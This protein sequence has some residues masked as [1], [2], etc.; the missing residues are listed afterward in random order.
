MKKAKHKDKIKNKFKICILLTLGSLLLNA[1]AIG[2]RATGGQG[3]DQSALTASETAE[4]AMESLRD[5]DL[6]QFNACTDNYVATHYNWIGIPVGREYRVFNE[7]Q[8]PGLKRGRHYEFNCRLSAMMMQ[9]LA[10]DIKAVQEEDGQAKLTMEI[11]NVD[12]ESVMD[13]YI[14]YLLE[15]MIE[16]DGIGLGQF[17]KDLADITDRDS[18]LISIME[19]AIAQDVMCTTEVTVTAYREQGAWRIHLDEEFINAFMGNTDAGQ[20]SEEMEQRMAELENLQEDKLAEWEEE[21][22]NKVERWADGLFR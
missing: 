9:K 5:L 17:I 20:Y 21:F 2:V 8:Q 7:L 16:S 11:T 10:W 15:N 12:M 18:A 14:L 4:R 3:T 6:E 19:D 22:T 1:C 13:E